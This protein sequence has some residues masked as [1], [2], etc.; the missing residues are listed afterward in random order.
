M[1][2]RLLFAPL[3]AL[4]LLGSTAFA[5]PAAPAAKP[6]EPAKPAA[7]TPAATTPAAKPG[8]TTPAATG[9]GQVRRDPN[10]QT[11][12]SPYMEQVKKGEDAYVARDFPGAVAAFQE[13]I[14]MEP[15]KMLA[16]YRIGEAQLA[17]GNVGEAEAQWQAALTKTGSDDLRAK[18]YFVLADLR[19]RQQKWADAKEAWNAYANYLQANPKALGYAATSVER[20]KQIDR[21]VK[22]EKDYGEVKVRIQ[23]RQ[24]ERLKEAEENAKKDTK[25]R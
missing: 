13:A 3:T 21:R 24:E 22:D 9:S 18:V 2:A 6:A 23:K 16:F 19:E 11:G 7:T 4:T 5:Q 17:A 10:G 25:N 20:I 1:R 8:A 14:K 15:Q 12:I